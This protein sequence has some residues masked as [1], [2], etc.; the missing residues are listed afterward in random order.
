MKRG[1]AGMPPALIV[2]EITNIN[3]QQCS[4]LRKFQGRERKTLQTCVTKSYTQVN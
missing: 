2:F 3:K 1:G 4:P